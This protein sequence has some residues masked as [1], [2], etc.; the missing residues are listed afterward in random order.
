MGEN[1]LSTLAIVN[2][3]FLTLEDCCVVTPFLEE[4]HK[5]KCMLHI[6]VVVS[7]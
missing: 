4:N 1:R 2:P 5:S 7:V 6:G 3:V